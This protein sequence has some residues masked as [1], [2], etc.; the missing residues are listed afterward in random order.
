MLQSKIFTKVLRESPKDEQSVNAQLLVRAGFIHKE[1]A[2]VYSFLPLGLRVLEKIK[3]II[4]EEMDELGGE[5]V[6]L[7]S[8]QDP[9]IWKKSGR[10]D[11][12]VVDNW[13]K[14]KL[15]NGT[16]V[17]IANTHEEP[18]ANLMKEYINS[19][20]D[21]PRYVYQFQTKFRNE[22]RAK[23]GLMR[24]RE[25]LM[26]DLYSFSRT[27]EEFKDFYEK[28]AVAYLKIFSRVGL[29]DYVF[30]TSASGGSFS[31]FSDEFQAISEA[32]ED[33]IYIDQK[34]KIAV[35]KEVYRDDVLAKLGLKKSDLEERK[36]IEIGNIFPL[37][38]KYSSALGLTFKDKNGENKPVIMGSYGIGLGRLMGTIAEIFHDDRG[39]V[40]PQEVAPF[41]IH[42]IQLGNSAK[43]QKMA[44]TIYDDLQK[45]GK[46]VL[47]DE[48][49]SKSAG[50]K[51]AEADLLGIPWRV[52]VSERNLE[53]EAVEVKRRDAEKTE[54]VSYKK[55]NKIFS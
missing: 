24:V 22:L 30:R 34:K 11:D 25:F 48:R 1:M 40:W 28:C 51:F 18:L 54:M 26:K 31:D 10:W 5:Q 19:W 7:T 6:L 16:D 12:K 41:Q 29:K 46:E 9:Q 8:L 53:E 44:K 43:V 38:T 37:G 17:G 35:N 15:A 36:A 39:I 42:L 13:F 4:K 2:G 52:V 27:E 32:G 49:E 23:S 3:Q 55:L 47:F 20:R 50:E 45:Q 21:L 14:T 33:I